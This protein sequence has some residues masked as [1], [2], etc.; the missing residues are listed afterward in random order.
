MIAMR[1]VGALRG[2]LPRWCGGA[3]L[4]A[5]TVFIPFAPAAPASRTLFFDDFAGNAL[6]RSKWNVVVTGITVNDEQ[7]AY[8]DSPD[9]IAIVHDADGSSGGALAI[10][11]RSRRG[12]RTPD[13]RTFDFVSGRINTRGKFDFTYGTAAARVKLSAGA[14]LW[15]AFW[16]LGNG[17]WPDTGEID[18]MENVGDPSWTNS[19]LHGP[20]Y[21]G[22]KGLVARQHFPDGGNATGWHVYAVDWAPGELVFTVDGHERWRV[23]RATVESRGRWAFENPKFMIVNQA[24]GGVY[25]H[26]VNGVERPYSGVPQST[27][28]AIE[29][30]KAVMLVDWVRVTAA[31]MGDPA[32]VAVREYPGDMFYSRAE[33]RAAFKK[34][35]EQVFARH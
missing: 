5:A 14:G 3:V 13:G 4:A 17:P 34:D 25:P 8:V 26:A 35:V 7:Q 24:I 12:F 18:V 29:A 15:P 19:A 11:T 22:D 31:P 27:V 32:R 6:A 16:V 33:S 28:A 20:G 30:G 9:T 23:S 1:A 21:S 10:T 2:R